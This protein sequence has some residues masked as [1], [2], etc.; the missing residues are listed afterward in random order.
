LE[1]EAR[2][3]A[4][5]L[6]LDPGLGML[7]VD[8]RARDSLACDLMEPIRPQVDAYVLDWIMRE[9]LKRAWFFEQPDGNCRLMASF[10]SQ[11]SETAPIWGRAVAPVAEF[12]AL[13]LWKT[14]RKSD[15][16]FPTRL[17]QSNKREAKGITSYSSSAIRHHPPHV[18][19]GCGKTIKRKHDYCRDCAAKN[20]TACLI[21]GARLGRV[22]AQ[23]AQAQERR[24]E[25]K[26]HHDLARSNWS[27]AAQPTWLNEEM[28]TQEILPALRSATLSQITSKIGVSIPYASDIRR[29]RRVPHPRHWQA[30]ADIVA[31]SQILKEQPIRDPR[32]SGVGLCGWG[33]I[34]PSR[35]KT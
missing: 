13:E 35:K 26:R 31:V 10:T 15:I 21:S 22:A 30:L 12:V 34:E 9:P 6:G 33:T 20:S 19:I 32:T 1:S 7:H 28:Y 14:I 5:T 18:C 17:T 25:T 2:L 23:T 29:G 3:A 16:P 27:P 11:L 4:A 24:K 8:T